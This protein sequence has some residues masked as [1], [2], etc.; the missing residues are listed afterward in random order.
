MYT[1]RKRR[2]H[3]KVPLGLFLYTLNILFIKLTLCCCHH[4]CIRS[5]IILAVA[6]VVIIAKM[7]LVSGNEQNV[8]KSGIG[9]SDFCTIMTAC[10]D[11]KKKMMN[12]D[13]L[14]TLICIIFLWSVCV[15]TQAPG[16]GQNT[17]RYCWS[18]GVETGN[19][20][21]S[22]GYTKKDLFAT[23]FMRAVW[24][25]NLLT[26]ICNSDYHHLFVLYF[27][28]VSPSEQY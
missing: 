23:P 20:S 1:P 4:G 21:S 15:N 12:I 9:K 11:D 18:N 25:I 6:L 27:F 24:L 5:L 8:K 7:V 16:H 17:T 19:F 13:L 10:I 2:K 28:Q 14:L 3:I 22:L 26:W